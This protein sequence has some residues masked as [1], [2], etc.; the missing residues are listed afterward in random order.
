MS[1]QD[2][3]SNDLLEERKFTISYDFPTTEDHTIDAKTLGVSLVNVA[4]LIMEGDKILNGE[5]SAVKVEVKANK[6]GSFEIEFVAWLQSGGIDILKALG[7]TAVATTP[8][9]ATLFGM[10][11]HL[12]NRVIKASFIRR[13]PT[14]GEMENFLQLDDDTEV[15]CDKSVQDLLQSHTVRTKLANVIEKPAKGIDNA[16][17]KFFDGDRPGEPLLL[18]N[19]DIEL[20]KAPPKKIYESTEV[21]TESVNLVFVQINN[22]SRN[23]WKAKRL[24]DEISVKMDDTAFLARINAKQDFPV[25]DELFEVVMETTKRIYEGKTT[26]S[27]IIIE[28]TRHRT[29]ADRKII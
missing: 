9:S 27:Y 11:K 28:V 15:K 8:A 21:T 17:V 7:I 20:F 5:H 3:N 4:E 1:D 29:T 19:E 2:K 13:S 6:E 12:K 14:T 24:D 25:K 23:G 10:I 22:T 16:V 26:Y 18:E